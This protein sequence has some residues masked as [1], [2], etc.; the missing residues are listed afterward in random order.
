MPD[1]AAET[2]D[3]SKFHPT[4]AALNQPRSLAPRNLASFLRFSTSSPPSCP[5]PS[6]NL[7]LQRLRAGKTPL[8]PQWVS[9]PPGPLR[10]NPPKTRHFEPSKTARNEKGHPRATLAT[11]PGPS[12]LRKSPF[13]GEDSSATIAQ[14]RTASIIDSNDPLSSTVTYSLPENL[15]SYSCPIADPTVVTYCASSVSALFLARSKSS[16]LFSTADTISD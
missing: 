13:V 9:S 5:M 6:Q 14:H 16:G 10:R 12:P 15:T 2:A 1:A 4:R 3:S 7:P 8:H 11:I